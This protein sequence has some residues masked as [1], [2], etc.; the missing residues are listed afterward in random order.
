MLATVQRLV[1]VAEGGIVHC[2]QATNLYRI[3]EPRGG[4]TK[5]VAPALA[6]AFPRSGGIARLALEAL[7]KAE[8]TQKGVTLI[9]VQPTMS[10]VAAALDWRARARLAIEKRLGNNE[11]RSSPR[12]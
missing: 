3:G 10:Y 11:N 1:R 8:S 4:I 7:A 5:P 6:K 2:R 12:A 9:G